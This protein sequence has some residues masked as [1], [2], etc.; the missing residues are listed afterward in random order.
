MPNNLGMVWKASLP[1]ALR[2]PDS[3]LRQPELPF[4]R[5][6]VMPLPSIAAHSDLSS[7][8]WIQNSTKNNTRLDAKAITYVNP[9]IDTFLDFAKAKYEF[10]STDDDLLRNRDWGSLLEPRFGHRA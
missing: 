10:F 2:V 4:S 8:Y 7:V 6:G 9:V 3:L 1:F 5:G